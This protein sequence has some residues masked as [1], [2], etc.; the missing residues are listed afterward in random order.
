MKA[1]IVSI[2]FVAGTLRCGV[3]L[4][5][6]T[7]LA[8]RVQATD[9][10][11]LGGD[12]SF[13]DDSKWQDYANPS[14]HESPGPTDSAIFYSSDPAYSVYLNDDYTVNYSAVS[15][16]AGNTYISGYNGTL[17]ANDFRVGEYDGGGNPAFADNTTLLVFGDPLEPLDHL[18]STYLT[19]GGN[20]TGTLW[21]YSAGRFKSL[22]GGAITIGGAQS[23]VGTLFVADPGSLLDAG[24][25][26][27]VVGK[28]GRG[29]L[30]LYNSG[31]VTG[32]DEL[33][34]GVES[35]NTFDNAVYVNDFNSLL[36]ANTIHAGYRGKGT[37]GV[38]AGATVHLTD[39]GLGGSLHIGRLS[40]AEG[41]VDV[42]NAG[43]L[44]D[45]SGPAQAIYVGDFGTGTLYVHDGAEADAN[46]LYIGAQS[47]SQGNAYVYDANSLLVVNQLNVG[48][49][50]SGALAIS[51]G[52]KVEVGVLLDIG[53]QNSGVGTVT[54]SGAGSTLDALDNDIAV[55]ISGTGSL[56]VSAGGQIVNSKVLGVGG[57]ANPHNN[58]FDVMG[59]GSAVHTTHLSVGFN[60]SVG[61]STVTVS[62]NAHMVVANNITLGSRATLDTTSG[63]IDATDATPSADLGSLRVGLNGWLNGAGTV[64]GNVFSVDTGLVSVSG[65]GTMTIDG[66]FTQTTG[67]LFFTLNGP[68]PAQ[69]SHLNILGDATFGGVLN[70]SKSFSFVPSA[71][72]TFDLLSFA[73]SSGTF[74]TIQLPTLASGL[75]WDT[76]QLYSTG[77]LSVAASLA[78]DFDHDG[79]V[80]GRDFLIWQ[81]GG[82]PSPLSGTD[83]ADWQAN[84][85]VGALTAANVTVPEPRLCMIIPIMF[86][87]LVRGKLDCREHT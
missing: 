11:W 21:L 54:V 19:V 2:S 25:N 39:E 68:N 3:I 74:S 47:G 23:G 76:S 83:L 42:T 66:D 85:G 53:F 18:K 77:V 16:T 38:Y 61:D 58:S 57:G 24:G 28:F 73:S 27:V 10:Y 6:A 41:S 59:A 81:R 29:T 8:G 48:H 5:I 44:L 43:T 78:G 31:Q 69:Y 80:D 32:I 79:D 52:G 55:G 22:P 60:N 20:A 64:K 46:Y 87:L 17:T 36:E 84:Y 86:A 37:L 63:A 45:A 70:V 71:G 67:Q 7:V 72:D 33:S 4:A 40:D 35:G 62:D 14:H 75:T 49:T 15:G 26:G 65:N 12:G 30:A 51:G 56:E 1:R 13:D 34:I 50:G 9:Y 82:S